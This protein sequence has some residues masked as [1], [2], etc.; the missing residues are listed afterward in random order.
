MQNARCAR[1]RAT[2]SR[3]QQT[4]HWIE[5]QRR[6]VRRS[7]D[8]SKYAVAPTRCLRQI[9]KRKDCQPAKRLSSQH[10]CRKLARRVAARN[11]CTLLR[12]TAQ[13]AHASTREQALACRQC[14]A[15]LVG[16][17]GA[18]VRRRARTV[19]CERAR[20]REHACAERACAE[21]ASAERACACAERACSAS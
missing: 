8:V 21:R 5:R 12:A 14:F 2:Y 16:L 7:A 20:A 13:G 9:C 15:Q 10:L 11:A 1:R 19:A 6:T 3:E 17:R 4:R 18:R